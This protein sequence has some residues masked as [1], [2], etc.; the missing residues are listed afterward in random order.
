MRMSTIFRSSVYLLDRLGTFGRSSA[1][2]IRA[3]YVLTIYKIY[4][5]AG[6]DEYIGLAT[7]VRFAEGIQIS[8]YVNS[9]HESPTCHFPFGDE[10]FST[11]VTELKREKQK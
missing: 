1:A 3:I 9:N 10:T 8:W 4:L 7:S 2:K 11:I 5:S 6:Y